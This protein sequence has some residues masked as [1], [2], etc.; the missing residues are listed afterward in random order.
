MFKFTKEGDE[1]IL[2]GVDSEGIVF[3]IDKNRGLT[4][5]VLCEDYGVRHLKE[6]GQWD[7]DAE[8]AVTTTNL[9]V[10]DHVED[11]KGFARWVDSA[12]SK[13]V[14]VPNE[15]SQE[16]FKE[17]YLDSYRSGYVKGVT[18]YR[19]GTM[20]TVLSAKE[21]KTADACDEEIILDDV[22]LPDSAPAVMKTIRAEN[23]KWVSVGRISRRPTRS[24]ICSFCK[25]ECR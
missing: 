15:Y 21:E 2:R 8:W 22:K 19:A 9:R 5:E 14:N 20:A 24:T 23:R 12:M 11:L 4:K 25:N 7:P 1:E 13:T 3:K 10:R 17:I 16:D 18:T 6:S